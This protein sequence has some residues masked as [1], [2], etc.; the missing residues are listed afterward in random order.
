MIT[1]F[2]ACPGVFQVTSTGSRR[3]IAHQK[4]GENGVGYV[5]AL[6]LYSGGYLTL[7]AMYVLHVIECIPHVHR[8]KHMR[9]QCRALANLNSGLHDVQHGAVIPARW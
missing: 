1:S 4:C 7:G 6:P 2:Q 9:M 3:P 5:V 8:C